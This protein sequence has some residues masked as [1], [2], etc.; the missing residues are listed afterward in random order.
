MVVRNETSV[1]AP[2]QDARW[3]QF[4]A[5]HEQSAA[6]H[7]RARALMPGGISHNIRRTRPFP[8]FI[9]RGE[10]PYKWD[11]DGNRYLDY[12]M[13]SASLLL[14]H[15][16]ACTRAAL[17]EIQ[18]Y[19]P[20]A[21]HELELE[22]A[23]LVCELV[24][25]AEEVRFCASGTE[26]T[27]LAARIARAATGRPKVVRLEGH[28]HGWNDYFMVGHR[29]PFDQPITDGV[30]DE[31]LA[32][33]CVAPD[34]DRAAVEELLAAGDVAAVFVEPSG[35]SWGTVPLAR[36]QLGFFRDVTART[37]TLLVFDETITGFRFSPGGMQ[38]L[39][40]VDPDLTALGKILTGGLQGAAV[41]GHADVLDV[42][43]PGR[44]AAEPHVVHYG[45]FNGHPLPAAVGVRTLQKVA[46][47]QPQSVADSH[48][49]EL[50]TGLQSIIDELAID[51]F[52]YGESSTFHIY[53]RGDGADAERGASPATTSRHEYLAIPSDVI[54]ALHCELRLRGLDLMSYNG[55]VA[56]SS[57][58][59]AQLSVA[60]EAF[61]GA[62]RT[63]RDE[64]IVAAR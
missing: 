38:G 27:M 18:G 59:R 29:A 61:D 56:S 12:A 43:R 64:R 19:V 9:Q 40:G 14:G 31:V 25:S 32:G 11:V 60:L 6:L 54:E 20:A 36:E 2:A 35:A 48:A 51:G 33:T 44:S 34:D 1:Q 55:G 39:A 26:A 23:Q 53:L 58:G 41:A 42:V 4:A 16:P 57:H 24:P 50:R 3:M 5:S 49:E 46:D 37:G 13:G 52:A 63:L 17:Q 47:G 7:Q 62:L 8:L 28:Y 21:C 45:T 30:L 10:G 22:W 15:D